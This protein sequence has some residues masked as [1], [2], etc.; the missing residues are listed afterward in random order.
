MKKA[1]FTLIILV[2]AFGKVGFAQRTAKV[3]SNEKAILFKHYGL[4]NRNEMVPQVAVWET[5]DGDLFMVN[6]EYDEYEYYLTTETYLMKKEIGWQEYEILTY[7]YDFAG[8][9]LEILDQ[10]WEDGEWE[11][12]ALA[13]Y[14]YDG[15]MLSEIVYQYWDGSQWQNELKEVYN[16]NGSTSTILYWE[17][18]GTTWSSSELYTFTYG[19]E[20]MEL[21]KQYMQGGAWQNEERDVF[22]LDFDGNITNILVQNWTANAWADYQ[23]TVY[24]YSQGVF[25]AK[26]LNEWNG[27]SWVG[28]L[29]F[30]YIYEDGNA[31]V[32]ECT[33]FGGNWDE[34]DGDIEMAYGY[35]SDTKTFYGSEVEMAYIDLTSVCENGTNLSLEVYPNP[36]SETLSVEAEGFSK[37][38]IY[39]L[40]GQKVLESAQ[41][42]LK[43]EA[44]PA[45]VY[46]LKVYDQL[47]NVGTQRIIVR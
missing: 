45:G 16:F 10:S 32:G 4:R 30:S 47:G 3:K 12:A 37:A 25:N 39:T 5:K 26:S 14:T 15:D 11:N 6:Y 43:A 28:L 27:S 18:N 2:M 33:E 19:T 36:V 41:Q 8:N 34:A 40:T 21:L 35:N 23:M 44:L 20:T 9:V 46:L 24:E 31:V 42:T 13:T 29:H 1:L 17:W 38:E 7:E 22:T